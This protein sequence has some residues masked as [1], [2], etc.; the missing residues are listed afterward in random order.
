M[1]LKSMLL[2]FFM[3]Y[4]KLGINKPSWR[5]AY[6]AKVPAMLINAFVRKHH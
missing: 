4:G 6:E 3:R 2:N 1:K 5:G